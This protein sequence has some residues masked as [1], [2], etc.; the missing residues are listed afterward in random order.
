MTQ[1]QKEE[2]QNLI[3]KIEEEGFEYAIRH[4][5]SWKGIDDEEFHELRN[6][7]IRAAEELQDYIRSFEQE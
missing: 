4:Y 6:S 7:Y 5:S 2:I 3:Y 1:K